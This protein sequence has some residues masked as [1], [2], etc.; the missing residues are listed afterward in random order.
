MYTVSY[1]QIISSVEGV[2]GFSYLS[3][4]S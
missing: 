2:F 4:F 1:V 3:E